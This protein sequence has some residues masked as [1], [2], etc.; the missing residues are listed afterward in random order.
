MKKFLSTRSS[1][2]AQE[3]SKDCQSKAAAT[4]VDI[5]NSNNG[6]RIRGNRCASSIGGGVKTKSTEPDII[7]SS[8]KNSPSRDIRS[9]HGII[10]CKVV[11]D[12]IDIPSGAAKLDEQ[13]P[14]RNKTHL[15]SQFA[16]SD[17]DDSFREKQIAKPPVKWPPLSNTD[18]WRSFEEAVLPLLPSFGSI[19]KRL[20]C[21]EDS[22]YKIGSE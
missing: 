10:E 11:L 5:L 13:E 7:D 3:K 4:C 6:Y 20:E 14:C 8:C 9:R 18:E 19:A 12:R 21:L 15:T 2:P 1:S 17:T 16:S 22:I